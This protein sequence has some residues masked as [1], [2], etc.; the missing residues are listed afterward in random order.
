M[1]KT[2]IVL[3]AF[4]R[5]NYF[6]ETCNSIACQLDDRPVYLFIDGPK[7]QQDLF[8]IN[9]VKWSFNN[10]F[11]NGEI[12]QEEDNIGIA[13]NTKKAREVVFEEHSRAIF[14]EDDLVI[15]PY[16]LSMLDR[17]MD[18]LEDDQNVGMINCFAGAAT[19]NNNLNTLDNQ[20]KNKSKLIA[21]SHTYA[22]GMWANKYEKIKPTLYEYYK[23]LPSIYKNRPH[24]PII[25]F[26]RKKGLGQGMNITS[27]DKATDSSM[28]LVNQYKVST[29]T[30]N[31]KYI[32]EIG[33]NSNT[34]AFKNFNWE[35]YPIYGKEVFDF[36]WS[37]KD[38]EE[39]KKE[40]EYNF[41]GEGV[42]E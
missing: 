10:C 35:N 18:K 29:Y 2:P 25:D 7:T 6:Y 20:D 19:R 36:D 13:F 11:P 26:W 8:N 5:P 21:C 3:I 17:L 42:V 33:D 24:Q 39:V 40:L 15:E 14:I 30:N 1:K 34:F 9:T 31:L 37:E 4:N 38:K 28:L 22:M 23:L 41:F 27:Q 16:Y 12:F 32:G